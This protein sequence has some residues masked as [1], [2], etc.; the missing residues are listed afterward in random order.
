MPDPDGAPERDPQGERRGDSRSSA[1]FDLATALGGLDQATRDF[2]ERLAEAQDLVN[3]PSPL[4]GV[5]PAA[6]PPSG[7]GAGEGASGGS[8]DSPAGGFDQRLQQAESEA[9]EYL[10]QAKRRADSLVAAMVAAV[11]HDAA[12]IRREA[13]EGIRARWSVVEADADRYIDEARRV[14][15]AIV[16]ER[17]ERIGKLSDGICSRARSLTAGME[18]AAQVRGQFDQFLIALSATADRIA[19]G[20]AAGPEGE[21]STLAGLSGEPRPDAVAA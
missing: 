7:S 12:T 6:P 5:P 8:P 3:A 18:D 4:L 10:E 16:A 20:S 21:I 9:R 17:Q 13:E 1:R 11:E 14:G 15:D 2:T 19:G